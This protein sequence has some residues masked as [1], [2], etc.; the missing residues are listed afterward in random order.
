MNLFLTGEKTSFGRAIRQ[1]LEPEHRF[2]VCPERVALPEPG[3]NAPRDEAS[4]H[5]LL[6]DCDAIIHAE[7]YQVPEPA[8][9]ADEALAFHR[10][11]TD[12][13]HLGKAALAAGVDRIVVIASLNVFDTID[14]NYRVDEMWRPRP[15]PNA[16]RLLPYLTAETVREFVR[17]GPLRGVCLRFAPIGDHPE[18]ETRLDSA[19]EAVGRALALAFDPSGYRWHV[20]HVA[21]SKRFVDRD[22]RRILGIESRSSEADQ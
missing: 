7:N 5:A 10:A 14:P 3:G 4:L 9:A 21:N 11:T 15:E 17:H 13:Y 16:A 18:K 6:H 2:R 12:T 20:I 8:D 22:A 19:L 1:K